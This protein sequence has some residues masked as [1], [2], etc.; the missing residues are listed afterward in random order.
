[1]TLV[2]ESR[3]ID[4][5]GS[6][7]VS[8]VYNGKISGPIYSP[9]FSIYDPT[10][11]YVA[12][13][14]DGIIGSGTFHN[15]Y[16]GSTALKLDS[17]I[18][19]LPAGGTLYFGNGTFQSSGYVPGRYSHNK[20]GQKFIGQGI[21]K[22]VIKVIGMEPNISQFA[23]FSSDYN[24]FQHY[25]QYKDFTIDCNMDG[26]SYNTGYACGGINIQGNYTL[27]KNVRVKNW[28]CRLTREVFMLSAGGGGQFSFFKN[29]T[30]AIIENCVVDSPN[31]NPLYPNREGAS[32]IHIFGGA[33]TQDPNNLSGSHHNGIIRNCVADGGNWGGFYSNGIMAY[34]TNGQ[35]YNNTIKNV[36]SAFYNDTLRIADITVR[37]NN[38]INC[39]SAF[40]FNHYL[41]NASLGTGRFLNN[42]ISLS[43]TTRWP[44]LMFRFLGNQTYNPANGWNF[45]YLLVS[46]NTLKF[47][48]G[49]RMISGGDYGVSFGSLYNVGTGI[50]VNNSS[51][52]FEDN[53][54]LFPYQLTTGIGYIASITVSNNRSS[55]T[56]KLITGAP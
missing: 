32:L 13:R 6:T 16:D 25:C 53:D 14:T 55:I 31:I 10:A 24:H 52:L 8:V 1:M 38:V 19:S 45:Q 51:S 48:S 5:N 17:Y 47:H 37:N 27:I 21:D 2:N 40:N 23:L 18:Q 36:S 15:P 9:H 26:Q 44:I 42:T 28:G 41:T 50:I 7:R 39:D 30:G 43:N 4:V 33:Y 54:P 49:D 22:T 11:T 34:G 46:G 56:N 35:T 29:G 3:D 20:T 12:Y